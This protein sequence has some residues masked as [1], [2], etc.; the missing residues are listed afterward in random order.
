MP[1]NEDILDCFPLN[2]FNCSFTDLYVFVKT[3][4]K[5]EENSYI[6]QTDYSKHFPDTAYSL[7]WQKARHNRLLARYLYI[8]SE[9]NSPM[10]K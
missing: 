4:L 8:Y 10:L 5:S 9:Y 6:E 2:N 7:S 1:I 3:P